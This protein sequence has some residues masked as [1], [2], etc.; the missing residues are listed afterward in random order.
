MIRAVNIALLLE[1][2][3]LF[4]SPMSAHGVDGSLL[5]GKEIDAGELLL[6]T[7]EDAEYDLRFI[8]AQAING[9]VDRIVIGLMEQLGYLHPVNLMDGLVSVVVSNLN[10]LIQICTKSDLYLEHS[11][12]KLKGWA[13]EAGYEEGWYNPIGWRAGGRGHLPLT[14]VVFYYCQWPSADMP[15]LGGP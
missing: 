3:K 1:E 15:F 5:A 4:R 13:E 10:E 7:Y 8:A 2:M 6:S 11:I 9:A 14:D 12:N